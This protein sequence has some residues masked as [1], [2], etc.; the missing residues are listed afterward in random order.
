VPR[1]AIG[2]FATAPAGLV[3]GCGFNLEALFPRL[4]TV[5]DVDPTRYAGTRHEIARYR[6]RPT[7]A[8]TSARHT[9]RAAGAAPWNAGAP[10]PDL[11]TLIGED[12]CVP[13]QLVSRSSGRVPPAC[14]YFYVYYAALPDFEREPD[15]ILAYSDPAHHAGEGGNILYIDGR[16]EF[17][18]EPD[19]TQRI[20]SFS[21][22]YESRHG[23]PPRIIPPR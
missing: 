15:W 2:A 8:R 1:T 3:G 10:P 18:R 5:P 7:H 22:S 4:A 16:V 6:R 21:A 12:L 13:D 20:E 23:R 11:H 14:D 9:P 19:F 17:V